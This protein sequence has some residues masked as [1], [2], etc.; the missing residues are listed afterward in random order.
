MGE[1]NSL[2]K[3]LVIGTFVAAILLLVLGC[4]GGS[5]SNRTSLR[6]VTDW[7][8]RRGDSVTGLSQRVQLIGPNGFVEGQFSINQD[9]PSTQSVVF[10]GL[11]PG[12]YRLKVELY[13]LRDLGGVKTGEL[14]TWL[15]V[16]GT[17]TFTCAVGEDPTSV[18]VTP[19]NASLQVQVAKQYYAT[20]YAASN[21]A[22]FSQ[23][24]GFTWTVL[25][26]NATVS[27]NGLVTGLAP[28]SGSIRATEVGSGLQNAAPFTI[29]PFQATQGKW[30]I[31]VFMNAA[32]DL[33]PFSVLNMNQMER[34]AQ[35][36]DVRFVVQWKQS[37]AVFSGSS[38]DGTRRYLAQPDASSAIASQLVL[39]LGL[40]V[41]MGVPETLRQFID[42]GQTYYPAD[43]YALIVWNHGSGWMQRNLEENWPT[44]AVS[45]DDETGNAIQIW[46]L[47]QA[48]GDNSVDILAWDASLMQ[49]VEVAYE[50]KDHADFVVGSEESPPG[51]GY[52]Y[53]DVLKVFRDNPDDTP[54]NLSKAFVDGMIN[55]PAYQ[56][57]K[58]TQSVLDTAKLDPLITAIGNLGEE[59]I[60]N[61]A[62]LTPL[63][64]SVRT[65]AQGYSPT[66][67]RTYRDLIDVVERLEAGTAI[68]SVDAACL[69]AKAAALDAIVWEAHN[70]HSAGS[71]GISFD[72]SRADTFTSLATDYGLLRFAQQSGWGDWLQ[73]AP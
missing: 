23:P 4:G 29:D 34:V 55:L 16:N 45:Y 18:R 9:S 38:F 66:L 36:P 15:N 69:A 49:M 51:E 2:R 52:P 54:R 35:N 8:N 68:A 10:D 27:A 61:K 1:S 58:I 11:Q 28:G 32:N 65:S 56:T 59:L 30:T 67:T 20:A 12:S 25:G 48:L 37:Q 53:D 60:A 22:V 43:H 41:D 40:D 70:S 13:S 64:Q 73:Q 42:W 57:R 17:D 26:G 14:N 21:R 72:F 33:H 3:L 47:A 71:R 46:E 7:T 24:G 5:G 31:L 19:N 63:A 62:A 44:R 50:I 6:Y 39:D